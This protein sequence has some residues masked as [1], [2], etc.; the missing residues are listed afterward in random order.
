M[1]KRKLDEA[2]IELFVAAAEARRPMKTRDEVIALL[3]RKNQWRMWRLRKDFKWLQKQLKRMGYN[4]E[5]AR[6]LL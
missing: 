3:E 5:E 2:D 4:P 1:G 6:D